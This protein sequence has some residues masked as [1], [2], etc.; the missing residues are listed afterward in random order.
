MATIEISV[1]GR[2]VSVPTVEVDGQSIVTT[3][4]W[5]RIASVHDEEWLDREVDDPASCIQALSSRDGGSLGADIFTFTQKVSSTQPRYSYATEL[6]SIAA[7]AMVGYQQWW[8]SVPKE[9]R[10]NV[11]RAQKRGVTVEV[12]PFDDALIAGIAEINNE[13]PFKQG[14]RNKHYGKSLAEVRRDEE[15]FLDR[16]EFIAAFREGK[17]VGFLKLVYRGDV[18][19]ILNLAS[20][21]SEYDSRPS[22]ILVAK[23]IEL[24]HEKGMSHLVYGMYNYGNKQDTPLRQFKTR[25]G[26]EEV[27]V[28]R[29][30]VALTARGRACM[31]LGLHRGL[32][33]VLPHS[34]IAFALGVR[35]RLLALKHISSGGNSAA[36][37]P[38]GSTT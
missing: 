31:A 5:L 1:D 35:A 14:R 18:A 22:N 7:V 34:V 4:K 24:C 3:G 29:Y 9:T 20:K 30:Y 13:S 28:P 33:G 12:V 38:A 19:S 21:T 36:E 26:F 23:A 16:C 11:R 10:K 27:L 6:D 15:S 17:M 2:W 32:L 8:E 37:Q 25:N